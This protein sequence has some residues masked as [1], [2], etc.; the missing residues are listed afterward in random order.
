MRKQISLCNS[1]NLCIVRHGQSEWNQQ[2]LFTGWR[3]IVLT[4]N[5]RIEAKAA[6]EILHETGIQ[7]DIAY[8]SLLTRAIVTAN[9]L[10]E[11]MQLAWVDV[12]KSWRLNE[13][14]YGAL[15]GK[16]KAQVVAIHGEEQVMRWR[17]SF[18]VRPPLLDVASPDHPKHHKR[19]A[20]VPRTDLPTGE[21]LKDVMQ[22]VM[23]LWTQEV[24]PQLQR[25]KKVLIVAHGNS[26]RALIKLLEDVSDSE[27]SRIELDTGVPELYEL[28]ATFHSKSRHRYSTID[29]VWRMITKAPSQPRKFSAL[30]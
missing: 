20:N 4:E 5:G 22:R 11:Q 7:F 8:T 3:D 14:H 9:L 18:D 1:V 28:D 15:Q 17:R 25:G 21:S 6:G 13:R 19:Y 27:I 16:N 12:N 26:L 23:P 30:S 24:V 2:N 10:L 29:Q